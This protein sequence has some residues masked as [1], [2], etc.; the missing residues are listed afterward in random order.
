[1]SQGNMQ[2][3]LTVKQDNKPR[4]EPRNNQSDININLIDKDS[5]NKNMMI[6]DSSIQSDLFD[7][8]QNDKNNQSMPMSEDEF[9]RMERKALN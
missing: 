6:D 5:Q 9:D 1:M 7:Q 8:Q 2:A 4:N 3:E